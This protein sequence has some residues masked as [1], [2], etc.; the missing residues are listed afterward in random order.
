MKFLFYFFTLFLNIF[1]FRYAIYLDRFVEHS[2]YAYIAVALYLISEAIRCFNYTRN[3]RQEF[4]QTYIIQAFCAPTLLYFTDF[5]HLYRFRKHK[6]QLSHFLKARFCDLFLI[7]IFLMLS[8]YELIG[9]YGW[10]FGGI[11]IYMIGILIYFKGSFK[12]IINFR[13]MFYSTLTI[14]MLFL[15]YNIAEFN[16]TSRADLVNYIPFYFPVIDNNMRL[17]IFAHF[18]L[19]IFLVSFQNT[20]SEHE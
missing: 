3:L 14:F 5:I 15:A 18:V 2:I 13:N 17:A 12:S 8:Q 1:F 10:F 20:R 9:F 16:I 11:V 6:L 7:L 19:S 4:L